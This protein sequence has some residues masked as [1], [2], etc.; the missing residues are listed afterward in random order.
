LA[1]GTDGAAAFDRDRV[2]VFGGDVAQHPGRRRRHLDRDLVGL[3]LH[4]RLVDRDGIAGLLEPLAD[5]RLG[6]GFAERR[7]ADVGHALNPSFVM[8]GLVPGIHVF[9]RGKDV[10]ARHK[11]GH[12][13]S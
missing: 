12:D 10:D 11:A 9:L 2:A 7:D 4:Q 1:A 5:G 8:P 13:V 3:E 6:D